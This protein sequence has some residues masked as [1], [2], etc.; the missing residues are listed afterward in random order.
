M[1]LR[2]LN[3]SLLTLSLAGFF[4]CKTVDKSGDSSVSS[5][6]TIDPYNFT[7]SN[8]TNARCILTIKKVEKDG[9]ADC[10]NRVINMPTVNPN[11]SFSY[12]PNAAP[13][14]V[15]YVF[16]AES[17]CAGANISINSARNGY[18]EVKYDHL[19]QWGNGFNNGTN[20]SVFLSLFERSSIC[21]TT[22]GGFQS[23]EFVNY[24]VSEV[25]DL[26]GGIRK[27]EILSAN[28]NSYLIVNFT[29]IPGSSYEFSAKEVECP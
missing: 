10:H 12:Y 3:L 17:G 1:L 9:I 20:G 23:T 22:T 14:T 25:K 7:C 18:C 26:V 24:P 19:N 27:L 8:E 29:N 11:C 15:A 4:A 5:D 6:V 28:Q 21:F 13:N 2:N 16:D